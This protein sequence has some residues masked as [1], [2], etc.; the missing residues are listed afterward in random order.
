M[1]SKVFEEGKLFL[2]YFSVTLHNLLEVFHVFSSVCPIVEQV[3]HPQ[4]VKG[5][6]LL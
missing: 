3:G 5:L 6:I 4:A 2:F 1:V